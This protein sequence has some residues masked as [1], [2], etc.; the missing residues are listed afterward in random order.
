MAALTIATIAGL[1]LKFGAPILADLLKSKTPDVV[2]RAIDKIGEALGTGPD[3]E[4]IQGRLEGD[5]DLIQTVEHQN[6]DYL[7]DLMHEETEQLRILH[8][9]MAGERTSKSLLQRAWRPFNGFLFGIACFSVILTACHVVWTQ[10]VPDADA[11]APILAL[12]GPVITAWAGV[13]GWI[14]HRRTAEKLAG[15]SS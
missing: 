13:V 8:D 15:V 1:A 11:I 2:D 7:V 12:I 4:A 6:Y 10:K 5:P 9:T 14:A 3:P